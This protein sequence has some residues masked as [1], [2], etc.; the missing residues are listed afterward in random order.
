MFK[1]DSPVFNFLNK[2]TAGVVPAPPQVWNLTLVTGEEGE[3]LMKTYISR[4][5]EQKDRGLPSIMASTAPPGQN[6]IMI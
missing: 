2:V 3:V 4:E 1:V 5:R 6:S